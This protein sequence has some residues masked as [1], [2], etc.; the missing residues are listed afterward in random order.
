MVNTS[1]LERRGRGFK[2]RSRQFLEFHLCSFISS[3][4]WFQFICVMY[5]IMYMLCI[6]IYNLHGLSCQEKVSRFSML[7]IP[8][9]GTS[10]AVSHWKLRM[11]TYGW[12]SIQPSQ[13]KQAILR[14]GFDFNVFFSGF[15][16]VS[17]CPVEEAQA[18]RILFLRETKCD[19]RVRQGT[20]WR[21]LF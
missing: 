3:F 4:H 19:R 2:S 14:T 6:Y 5:I 1:A 11:D 15:F 8:R 13:P 18:A 20:E 21:H 17:A 10:L 12:V 7:L 16:T 9:I